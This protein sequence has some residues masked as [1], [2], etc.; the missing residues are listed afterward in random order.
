MKKY[1]EINYEG[2]R[3]LRSSLC[4]ETEH[5]VAGTKKTISSKDLTF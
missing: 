4:R 5:C 1:N 3:A 2:Y